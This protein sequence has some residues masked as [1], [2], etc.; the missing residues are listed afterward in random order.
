MN[1][2][3]LVTVLVFSALVICTNC[4]TKEPKGEETTQGEETTHCPCIERETLAGE[5]NF[6]G[7]ENISFE[8]Y[9]IVDGSTSASILNSLI[10]CK[11]LGLRY[12][13][14]N[15]S[16]VLVETWI[17]PNEEDI[18]ELHQDFF[19]KRVK[20]SQTHGA[21][22]NLI[23]GEADI[24]LTHRT[25]APDERDYAESIGVSLIETS[26]AL[27]AFVFI[28]NQKN[29]VQS[30]T[31][32]EIRKIYTKEITNWSQVG[33]N[34]ASMQVFTRPR[35]SGSE[36][37]FRML[38]MNDLEPGNFPEASISLMSHVFNEIWSNENGICYT[39]SNYKDV[40]AK[41]CDRVPVIAINE[42]CP[43]EITI[44][45]KTYPFISEVR[46]AIRS[47]LDHNSMA[48]KLYEWLQ[49]E[50]A[51]YTIAECGFF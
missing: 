36:E 39:F 45:N 9:P 29:P 30:L 44:K 5:E 46:V 3:A 10:A 35:N 32:D 20:T 38:V 17:R 48:Y 34:N 49:S 1:R 13:W 11:L 18:P 33:G 7:I 14:I 27:D 25:I 43:S 26:I 23:D 8:N 42:I 4:D 40:M 41:M 19:T 15:A 51:K 21:F 12:T 31:V 50:H 22:M 24:I 37:V 6:V 16:A 2:I 28:V 47:D